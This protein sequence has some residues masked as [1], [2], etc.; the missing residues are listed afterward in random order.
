LSIEKG[1]GTSSKLPKRTS[2]GE[3]NKIKIGLQPK[4]PFRQRNREEGKKEG[5][6]KR[7]GGERTRREEKEK[8]GRGKGERENKPPSKEEGYSAP[9]NRHQ[10]IDR[11]QNLFHMESPGSPLRK[12]CLTKP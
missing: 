9:N 11:N 12:M 1:K 6:R 2:S 5:K 8:R 4:I 10:T 7:E 3:C